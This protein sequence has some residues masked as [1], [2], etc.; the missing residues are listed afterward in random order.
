MRLMSDD[1]CLLP[2]WGFPNCKMLRRDF[3]LGVYTLIIH[4]INWCSLNV[5]KELLRLFL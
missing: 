2:L 3:L 4:A 5:F 1:G